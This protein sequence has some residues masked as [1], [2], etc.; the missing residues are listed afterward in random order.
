MNEKIKIV[1][2]G[3]GNKDKAI[4]HALTMSGAEKPSVLLIPSAA[5]NVNSYGRKVPVLTEYFQSLG[6]DVNVL[7]E[8]GED[9]SATKIAHEL[10]RNS[11][12]YTIG[13]SSPHMLRTMARHGTDVA[14]ADAIR[15]GTVHAG[16]SAGALLPFE[17]AHSNTSVKPSSEDWDYQYLDML[18]I[19]PGVATAHAD[20]HDP[21]PHGDRPDT[22]LGALVATFPE[23]ATTGY[24]IDN[25]AALIFNGINPPE[26]IRSVAESKARTVHR[27]PDGSIQIDTL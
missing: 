13:G 23:N 3:G 8:F 10:G 2:I 11:L 7:H 1:A 18:G 14:V 22:R 19:I 12:I 27:T 9:P 17:L 24:A 5:S 6:V 25:G 21:T 20:Q 4:E 15:G 26:V 16:L